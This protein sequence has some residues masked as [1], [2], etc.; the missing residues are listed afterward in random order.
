VSDDPTHL[1]LLT[2]LTLLRYFELRGWVEPRPSPVRTMEGARTAIQAYF[3]E[4]GKRPTQKTSKKWR[5]WNGWLR[6]QGSSLHKLCKQMGLPGGLN[7]TRTMEGARTAVQTYFDEHG[8]R[9]TERTN[10]EWRRWGKWLC[11]QGSSLHKLCGEIGLP[12][13]RNLTRTME[14]ARTA[15]QAYFDEHGKRP[16]QKTSKEWHN[17]GLWLHSQGSSLRKLCGEIG[18]PGGLNLIRTMDGARTAVQTYFDE[19]GKRPTEL[20]GKEWMSWNKWLR[21]QGSSLRKLCGEMGL[22]GGR[23]LTRTMNGAKTAIQTYFDEHGKRP[24]ILIG[25]EWDQWNGWLSGQGSS[26][27]KLCGEMGLPGGLNLTRTM[28]GARTAIQ[29]YFDEHGKR[30]RKRAN[31]EWRN[32]SAWLYYRGSSLFKLCKQMVADGELP[33]EALR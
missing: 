28:D 7:L 25:K 31:K 33:P 2:L 13:G 3:D 17:W 14:G 6:S 4:H 16:A 20:T 5:N 18:L 32:W 29:T 30:P 26:L 22:P 1:T 19:H 12:G 11:Y 27:H 21:S 8:K 24:I 23:N 15:I 10:K 9:P